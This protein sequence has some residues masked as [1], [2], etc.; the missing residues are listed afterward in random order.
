LQ[1]LGRKAEAEAL[2]RPL[3]TPGRLFTLSGLLSYTHFDPRPFPN[4]SAVLEAQG[5]QR[6]SAVELSFACKRDGD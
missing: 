4:L 5:V 3:D 1:T 2:V 6:Q